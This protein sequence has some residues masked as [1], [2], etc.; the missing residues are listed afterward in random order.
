MGVAKRGKSLL[1]P[2]LVFGIG[3]ALSACAGSGA[4]YANGYGYYGY[5]D[6]YDYGYLDSFGFVGRDRDHERRHDRDDGHDHGMHD[7]DYGRHDGHD[8]GRH[9]GHGAII[10]HGAGSGPAFVSHGPS[11]QS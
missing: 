11:G 4:D 8:Y 7:H 5:P 2:G 1:G 9:D 6:Y 10:S 3:I